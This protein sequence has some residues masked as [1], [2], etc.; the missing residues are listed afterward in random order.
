VPNPRIPEEMLSLASHILDTKAGHF[1]T[2]HSK[3]EFETELKKL[4]KRKAPRRRH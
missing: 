2:S 4:V 1:D 3:D